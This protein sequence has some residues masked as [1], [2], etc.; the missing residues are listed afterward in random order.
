MSRMIPSILSPEVK[1]AA[2]R[3]VFEWFRDAPSRDY[4]K[5]TYGL[6]VLKA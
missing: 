1:S 6:K 5:H 2:E 3:H 4:T